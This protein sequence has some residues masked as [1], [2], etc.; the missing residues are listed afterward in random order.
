MINISYVYE[1]IFIHVK[2]RSFVLLT[3]IY[4]FLLSFE[5]GREMFI[6]YFDY[7]YLTLTGMINKVSF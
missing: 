6:F 4:K 2:F 1:Y 5:N 7:Y 3:Y